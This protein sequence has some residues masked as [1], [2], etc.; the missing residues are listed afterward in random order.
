[1]SLA[2]PDIFGIN[3]VKSAKKEREHLF[4][5]ARAGII[6]R[7]DKFLFVDMT[8]YTAFFWKTV[9]NLPVAVPPADSCALFFSKTVKAQ[10]GAGGQHIQPLQWIV[11]MQTVL[12]AEPLHVVDH[13]IAIHVHL[14]AGLRR[15]ALMPQVAVQ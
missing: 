9:K 3:F 4:F 6:C 7:S 10:H 13:I 1:M 15:V 8:D 5:T 11:Q 14:A 12:F 2:H